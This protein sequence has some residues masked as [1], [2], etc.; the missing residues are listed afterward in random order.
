MTNR[1]NRKNPHAVA[2]GRVRSERKAESS[3]RNAKLGGETGGRPPREPY[4]T[5]LFGE[6]APAEGSSGMPV[7]S[8]GAAAD[9]AHDVLLPLQTLK[10]YRGGYVI[11]IWRCDDLGEVRRMPVSE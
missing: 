6:G 1:P 11:A 2:L 8:I 3:R 7:A 10:I 9:Y 5:R 4:H